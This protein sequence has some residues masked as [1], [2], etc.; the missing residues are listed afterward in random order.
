M[1]HDDKAVRSAS[2]APEI[3]SDIA[4]GSQQAAFAL[5]AYQPQTC[6]GRVRAYV[7]VS[8]DTGHSHTLYY[9]H[10]LFSLVMW[11]ISIGPSLAQLVIFAQQ[12]AFALRAYQPRAYF[13]CARAGVR[14]CISS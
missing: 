2:S 7:Y 10:S 13:S 1:E 9:L 12:A 5:R 11:R 14:V 3:F 6:L 8:V 4:C